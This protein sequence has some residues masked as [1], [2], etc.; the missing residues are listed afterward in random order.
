METP[1]PTTHAFQTIGVTLPTT[2][3]KIKKAY[4]TK[5]LLFHPDKTGTHDTAP[6]FREVQEAYEMLE[7]ANFPVVSE[8]WLRAQ[9]AAEMQAKMEAERLRWATDFRGSMRDYSIEVKERAYFN[10]W[11]LWTLTISVTLLSLP[12][13]L[14]VDYCGETNHSKKFASSIPFIVGALVGPT[15]LYGASVQLYLGTVWARWA[16]QFL[17]WPWAKTM[18]VA[19]YDGL[20]LEVRDCINDLRVRPGSVVRAVMALV[21]GQ[22]CLCLALRALY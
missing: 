4:K 9:Q 22:V 1:T 17:L 10:A 7:A 5:V 2:P 14:F 6:Q 11:R 21:V 19:A 13:W 3:E 16:V 8:T 12:F 15:L 18:A 20:R